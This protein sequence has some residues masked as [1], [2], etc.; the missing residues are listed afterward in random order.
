MKSG[1]YYGARTAQGRRA[2]TAHAFLTPIAGRLPIGLTRIRLLDV[3]SESSRVPSEDAVVF[4]L[5]VGG[6]FEREMIVNGSAPQDSSVPGGSFS[7][8]DMRDGARLRLKSPVDAVQ[9]YVPF[10]CLN[11]VATEEDGRP[12]DGLKIC[13][14]EILSDPTLASLAA[15][16]LPSFLRPNEASPLFID[17]MSRAAAV[18]VARRYAG[19]VVGRRRLRRGG[20]APWQERRIKELLDANLDGDLSLEDLA[21]ECRLSTRHLTR[22]FRQSTGMPPHKWLLMR[23]IERAKHLLGDF[24][25]QI[26][27]I[28]TSCGF[29]DQ[30]H[31][32]RSF[33]QLVGTSPGA[34]RRHEAGANRLQSPSTHSV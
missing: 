13:S 14:A 6:A 7:F 33:S 29:S 9:F 8:L 34:W 28:A 20:L 2:D 24:D 1:G 16:L 31:F 19:A 5:S 26:S 3:G 17:H 18:H 15:A 32:T 30:S 22:A 4:T 27:E 21:R 23:R 11:A 12:I 10:E 25:L